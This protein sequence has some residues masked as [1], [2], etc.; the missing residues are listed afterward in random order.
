MQKQL[1]NLFLIHFLNPH[2]NA[3]G[4]NFC[5]YCFHYYFIF[6]ISFFCIKTLTL[7]EDKS[8]RQSCIAYERK[9]YTLNKL[10]LIN[11]NVLFVSVSHYESSNIP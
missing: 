11:K 7:R 10:Y 1:Q 4:H 5:Q 6:G 3:I 9:M 8:F 2:K